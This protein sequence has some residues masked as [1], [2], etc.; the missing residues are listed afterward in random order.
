MS[1][2]ESTPKLRFRTPDNIV[3]SSASDQSAQEE[4]MPKVVK[5]SKS[6]GAD[7]LDRYFSEDADGM[8]FHNSKDALNAMNHAQWHPPAEDDTIPQ[9][10]EQD[11]C[12]VRRLVDAFLDTGS[13]MDTEGNAY[14]KRLTPGTNVFYDPWTIERC[15]WEILVCPH[16]T[17]H[18]WTSG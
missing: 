8:Y 7:A 2:R 5:L 11:R 16:W 12:I 14:R 3:S 18:G 13:A 4:Y 9:D 17:T 10:D 1:S 6:K 15:A